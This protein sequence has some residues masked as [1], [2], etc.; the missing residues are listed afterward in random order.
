MLLALAFIV[1]IGTLAT[2]LLL[3]AYTTTRATNSYRIERVRRYSA[4]G[5]LQVAVQRLKMTPSYVPPATATACAT[6]GIVEDPSAATQAPVVATGAGMTVTCEASPASDKFS[7][8]LDGGQKPRDFTL[9]VRCNTSGPI[10]VNK[11]LQ[12]GTGTGTSTEVGRAR[13][14]FEID[15]SQ[16]LDA[17]AVVPKVLSWSIR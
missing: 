9:V 1:V 6:Y 15:Y 13:V 16:P 8:D 4:D 5:A 17:R 2:G 7:Y 12:C 10:V 3:F 11:K 14:R